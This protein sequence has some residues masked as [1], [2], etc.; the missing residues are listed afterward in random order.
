[1]MVTCPHCQTPAGAP[2]WKARAT[3]LSGNQYGK[4]IRV[5]CQAC[6]CW[7]DNRI[8]ANGAIVRWRFVG[9]HK[10]AD[11]GNEWHERNAR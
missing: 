9:N 8:D 11:A 3:H 10:P 1:M 6:H 7:T 2:D 5:F 4:M